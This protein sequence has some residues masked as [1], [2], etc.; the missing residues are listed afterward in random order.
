M[1]KFVMLYNPSASGTEIALQAHATL[2]M[3][4][5][6]HLNLADLSKKDIQNFF[7]ERGDSKGRSGSTG[8]PPG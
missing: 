5:K 3:L 7:G 6:T 1:P 4:F 2:K 8:A